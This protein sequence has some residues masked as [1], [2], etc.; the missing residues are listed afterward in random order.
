MAKSP[1]E[2][3]RTLYYDTLVYDLPTLNHLRE[4]FGDQQLMV[5]SDYPFVIR[6]RRPGH[7]LG[8]LELSEQQ[9]DQLAYGNALRFL[10]VE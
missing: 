5:G 1:L 2:Y 4:L 9:R 7:W 10:G 3:A 6:E 8:E